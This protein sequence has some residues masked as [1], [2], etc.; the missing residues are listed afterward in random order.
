MENLTELHFYFSE[1]IFVTKFACLILYYLIYKIVIYGV[2]FF[3]ETL[4]MESS[5]SGNHSN[6]M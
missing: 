3:P 6:V 4:K 5:I 2:S 1:V